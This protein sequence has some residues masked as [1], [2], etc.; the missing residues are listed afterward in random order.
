[1][2]DS[3]NEVLSKT[4]AND[5]E[6]GVDDTDAHCH[7]VD[8]EFQLTRPILTGVVHLIEKEKPRQAGISVHCDDGLHELL[9]AYSAQ[10]DIREV[11]VHRAC[12]VCGAQASENLA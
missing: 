6:R 11:A 3:S 8:D 5:G 10:T 4:G 12:R 2:Y 9:N 7:V 1:M